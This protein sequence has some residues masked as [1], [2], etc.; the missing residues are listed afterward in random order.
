MTCTL[1]SNFCKQSKPISPACFF[2]QSSRLQPKQ[3][4]NAIF[5]ALCHFIKANSHLKSPYDLCISIFLFLGIGPIRGQVPDLV[6][7]SQF[8][9]TGWQYID[10][11]NIVCSP[12]V[13]V[14]STYFD[15]FFL[16]ASPCSRVA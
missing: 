16:A 8:K 13:M 15:I 3:R 4:V 9:S 7:N 6:S 10:Y 12:K 2:A 1:S 11:W 14:Q 5:A